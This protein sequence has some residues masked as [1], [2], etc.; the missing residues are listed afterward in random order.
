MKFNKAILNKP[1]QKIT[2]IITKNKKNDAKLVIKHAIFNDNTCI[3]MEILA[4]FGNPIFSEIFIEKIDKI[5]GKILAI[6]N[7]SR[8]LPTVISF[9]LSFF[10]KYDKK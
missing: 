3:I 4:K 7:K 10:L 8:D 2:G 9:S 1:K 6:P 5:A